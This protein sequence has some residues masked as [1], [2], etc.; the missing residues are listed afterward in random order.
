MKPSMPNLRVLRSAWF[1]LL[2]LILAPAPGTSQENQAGNPQVE[3]RQVPL[4]PV[5]L[6]PL[7]R[8][9]LPPRQPQQSQQQQR[10]QQIQQQQQQRQ[11][12]EQ[13]RQ[14]QLQ[15]QRQNQQAGRLP[16]IPPG[17]GGN[18]PNQ[19]RGNLA[20]GGNI[21]GG[22]LRLP[23]NARSQPVAGGGAHVFHP[24]GRQWLVDKNNHVTAFSHNNLQ[25]KFGDDGRP[26][27]VHVQQPGNNMV[28][29]RSMHGD[30]ETLAIRPG[31]VAVVTFGNDQGYIQRPMQGRPGYFQRT[32][33]ENGQPTAHVYRGYRYGNIVYFRYM[34]SRYYQ[35]GFYQW[36]G[37]TW[38]SPVSYAWQSPG[39]GY[40][41][42]Y[43]TPS[44]SYSSRSSWLTDFVLNANL[45]IAFQNHQQYE[46]QQ[47]GAPPNG[48]TNS[49]VTP[50]NPETKAAISQEVQEQISQE[51]SDSA[52]G[53]GTA[54]N[55]QAPP[56]V[57]D[58]SQR[59][60]VVSQSL[61][62]PQGSATCTLSPGD[63][64]YRSGDNVVA[65]NKVGVNVVASKG[66]DCPANT[67]TQV[68]V[69]TL[70]EMHNQFREQVDNGLSAL[71]DKQGQSGMPPGPAANGRPNPDGTA[72]PDG[73]VADT[74][75]Q[76]QT[77]ASS[78]ESTASDG[79]SAISS[80]GAGV[81]M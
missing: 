72:Q 19:P 39:G 75:A 52:S 62:V 58:P 2:I 67:A 32:S 4:K 71:A 8:L 77:A 16:N 46:T 15:L 25:A 35:P 81:S 66:G 6:K 26:N 10:Q 51:S 59:T 29:V 34:P 65:G 43:F 69:A 54:Q 37:G 63:V 13:Q 74:L 64:V 70:Q 57:M 7:P 12:A 42:N 24:D 9:T 80:N 20:A 38:R 50:V 18:N 45:Q 1:L 23:P 36:A 56:P 44:Q 14:Q 3:P 21:P 33:L 48:D 27:F 73:N 41:S 40:Y 5:P 11:Q 55:G 31:N 76:Q 53:A 47:P 22:G 30:R 79:A 68:D 17:R 49:D 61:D 28:V 78:A 60:I